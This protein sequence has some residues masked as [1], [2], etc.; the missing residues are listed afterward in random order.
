MEIE[1]EVKKQA[2]QT[3]IHRANQQIAGKNTATNDSKMTP[4]ERARA[5]KQQRDIKKAGQNAAKEEHKA[6][7]PTLKQIKAARKA[8]IEAGYQFPPKHQ[9]SVVPIP[10]KQPAPGTNAGA[11]NDRAKKNIQQPAKKE[12]Q[13]Q[14]Q[15]KKN[16]SRR[17]GGQEK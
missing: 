10:P 6:L 14:Q 7:Q 16:K 13:G 4:N 9:I 1:T 8:M 3:A 15:T 11:N 5:K 2:N 17:N 12:G